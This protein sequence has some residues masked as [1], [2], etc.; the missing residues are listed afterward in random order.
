MQ[1]ALSVVREKALEFLEHHSGYDRRNWLR[2]AQIDAFL[3]FLR[4]NSAEDARVLEIS[5]G[6]NRTWRDNCP[7]YTSVDYPAFNIETDIL[8]D[9]FDFVIADQVIEHVRKPI[10][11][12]HNIRRM[13]RIGGHAMIAAPFLFRIHP[14]PHDFARWSPEGLKQLLIE[15]GFSRDRISIDAWGNKQCVRAH[16]G[17]RVRDYGWFRPMANEPE[18]PI[19][20]WAFAQRVDHAVECDV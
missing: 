14:R 18:Y 7:N 8:N 20:V 13:L 5:P 10:D 11:A 3:D 2:V 9:K 15:S 12:V 16:I 1:P 4:D 6:T 17:G 19:M